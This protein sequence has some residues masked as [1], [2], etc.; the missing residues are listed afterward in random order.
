MEKVLNKNKDKLEDAKLVQCPRC[1]G[2]G[3]DFGEEGHCYICRGWGE[4]WKSNSGWVRAK[5]QHLINS[6]LY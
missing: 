1:K 4:V 6:Q 5:Y 2:F 3:A